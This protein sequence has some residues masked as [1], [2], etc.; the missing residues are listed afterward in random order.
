MHSHFVGF[1]MRQLILFAGL[2]PNTTVNIT[3]ADY[4][5]PISSVPTDDPDIFLWIAWMFVILYSSFMFIKSNKGQQWI[6]KIR[7]LWQEHQHID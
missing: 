1:V 3:D 2:E 5:G 7:I 4:I 6:T